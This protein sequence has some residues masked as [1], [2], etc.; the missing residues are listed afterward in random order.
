MPFCALCRD[1]TSP[2]HRRRKA[3]WLRVMPFSW[4][5]GF[6]I[7]NFFPLK[8]S[9]SLRT[10][11]VKKRQEAEVAA[12]S[13]DTETFGGGH[14]FRYNRKSSDDAAVDVSSAPLPWYCLMSVSRTTPFLYVTAL[15]PQR[16]KIKAQACK[17]TSVG[18]LLWQTTLCSDALTRS[19]TCIVPFNGTRRAH[20][21]AWCEK[22]PRGKRYPQCHHF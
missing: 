13:A 2:L 18:I 4:T 11:L 3:M 17:T 19:L 14:D 12:V 1:E 6:L 7:H 16:F 8:T 22:E 10:S 5:E 15:L 20:F 21:C 9:V